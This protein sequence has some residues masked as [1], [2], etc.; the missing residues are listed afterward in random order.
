MIET[1]LF[2]GCAKTWHRIHEFRSLRLYKEIISS[3]IDFRKKGKKTKTRLGVEDNMKLRRKGRK[4]IEKYNSRY[5][6]VISTGGA[7]RHAGTNRFCMAWESL[8]Q[9]YRLVFNRRPKFHCEDFEVTA[10][11]PL[12]TWTKKRTKE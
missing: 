12:W 4:K 5:L 7:W 8:L 9:Q 1:K 3:W 6:N 2:C 10:Q 11:E